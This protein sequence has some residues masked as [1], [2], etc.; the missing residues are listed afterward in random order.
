MAF[1]ESMM[2]SVPLA[3]RHTSARGVPLQAFGSLPPGN[4]PKDAWDVP[5]FF[6]DPSLSKSSLPTISRRRPHSQRSPC[7]HERDR[8]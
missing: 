3:T 8:V 2:E 1:V 5:V 4:A 6:D 7:A